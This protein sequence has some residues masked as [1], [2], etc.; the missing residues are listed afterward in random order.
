MLLQD[1]FVLEYSRLVP[2]FTKA[3]ANLLLFVAHW[4]FVT[5]VQALMRQ[6][7]CASQNGCQH[8]FGF[9]SA[10]CLAADF[11]CNLYALFVM[12]FIGNQFV[13]VVELIFLLVAAWLINSEMI[14]AH[15]L[16]SHT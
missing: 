7:L 6:H 1:S 14:Y 8:C 4:H 11:C 16:I 10:F 5:C 13:V 15:F 9:L 3:S 2:L 12:L